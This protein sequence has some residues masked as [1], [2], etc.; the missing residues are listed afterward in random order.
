M[1]CKEISKP[2]FQKQKRIKN[3]KS[4]YSISSSKTMLV[5]MQIRIVTLENLPD[6]LLS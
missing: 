4:I 3:V 5:G 2:D 1:L 6:F